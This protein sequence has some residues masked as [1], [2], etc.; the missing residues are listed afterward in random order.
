MSAKFSV[1]K[2]EFLFFQICKCLFELRLERGVLSSFASQQIS[3]SRK[4]TGRNREREI[5]E[6]GMER[7]G[8]RASEEAG[9]EK[10]RIQ[11]KK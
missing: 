10:E 8:A 2:A 5:I 6:V 4:Q 9:I 11:G 7:E 3:S 1:S